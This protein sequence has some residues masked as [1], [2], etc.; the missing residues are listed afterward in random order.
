MKEIALIFFLCIMA[1]VFFRACVIALRVTFLVFFAFPFGGVV[2]GS[3]FPPQPV[4]VPGI[5]SFLEGS[6]AAATGYA[7][8]KNA[9]GSYH[10][11][12]SSYFL[13]RHDAMAPR[14]PN[15]E[16]SGIK[17]PNDIGASAYHRAGQPITAWVILFP[18]H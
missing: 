10:G 3:L 12:P 7:T 16:Q 14:P 4:T 9:S 2:R 13:V 15:N 1:A 11:L 17:P 18:A 5:V 6:A 8:R